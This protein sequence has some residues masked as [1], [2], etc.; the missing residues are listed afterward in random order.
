MADMTVSLLVYSKVVYW[1]E[2][3]AD[4]LVGSTAVQWAAG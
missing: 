1:D 4:A 3:V 2:M